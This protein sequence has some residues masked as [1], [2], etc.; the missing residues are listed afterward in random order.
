MATE[1]SIV[2]EAPF[3]E[4]IRKRLLT[5]A[6]ELAAQPVGAEGLLPVSQLAPFSSATTQAFDLAQAGLGAYQPF[7]TG[8][9]GQL[10]AAGA[11]QADIAATLDPLAA[12]GP[13]RLEEARAAALLGAGDITGR[14]QDFQ[15]PFQQQVID[16]FSEEATRQ[17]ELA[18]IRF[19]DTA[20][21]SGALGGLGRFG[22]ESELEGRLAQILGQ[23]QAGLRSQGFTTALGAAERE[24]ARRQQLPGQLMGIEQLQYQLPQSLASAQGNLAAQQQQL[25]QAQAGLGGLTQQL[26]AQDVALLSQVGA[27]QQQQGQRALDLARQNQ[28]QQLYEP[29]QRIG[30]LSDILKGQPSVQSTLTTSTTP[31]TNPISQALGAGISLAGIFGQGGF[32]TGYLFGPAGNAIAGQG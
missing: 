28:L 7:L 24:A 3:L 30:Y 17:N 16:R 23:Q 26:G 31:K 21:K 13:E 2:R 6:E 1:T 22:G 20:A 25:G 15:D 12:R 14:I 29:Y 4:D 27:Q 8:A 10:G 32:G 5:S 9:A 19:R 18:K 11:T